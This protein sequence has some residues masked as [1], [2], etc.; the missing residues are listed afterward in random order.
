[1]A[2]LLIGFPAQAPA[3][4]STKMRFADVAVTATAKDFSG[5][6]RGKQYH[7]PDFDAVLDR[8][9]A[10][11]VEKVMLT[12]MSLSD[13]DTN[14]SIAK[15]R[16]EGSCFVTIGIHPYHAAE[17]DAEPEG[18]EDAHFAK[19]AQSVRDAL[20]P[21]PNGN[22]VLAAY[23]EL[24]LD[25]DRLNHAS[26]EAQVRTFKRQLDLF[27]AEEFDLPLFLHCRAAFDDFVEIIKPYLPQL[28]RRGLVHSFVG[29]AAQMKEL[30]NLGFDVSVNGFSF[31]DK[32]SLEMA[33]EI[34]L[35]RLQIETDAPWGEI[36]AG[37]EVAK[38]YLTNAPSLPPS[39]KKDKFEMG[40]MVKGRN[41]SCTMARVA[42]VVA[43][44][45]GITV[46]EVAEAAW[47]NS[48][49]MFGLGE[50]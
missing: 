21:T 41:E 38:K 10:A 13:V 28:P 24:G 3:K 43:G 34:P 1:M 11:G 15:S 42:F 14:L 18:G 20:T 33:R 12:G 25:Y 37:S 44:L 39:K 36:P 9:L 22:T 45:K 2:D 40:L 35:E 29:S 17:P 31:Q 32:E 47:K 4:P 46:E 7:Q 23:G 48:V 50:K 30:V 8:A 19:L 26:K 16:P 49:E 27:V 6:Y 5:F